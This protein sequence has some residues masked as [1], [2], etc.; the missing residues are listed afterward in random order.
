MV[1][2]TPMCCPF[3][4]PIW[5]AF[6][7]PGRRPAALSGMARIHR[8]AAATW[9]VVLESGHDPK[10]GKRLWQTFAVRG[11]KR[12]AEREAADRMA[13]VARGTYVDRS[14]ETVGEFLHRWLRPYV[15]PSLS[16]RSRLRYRDIVQGVLVPPLGGVPI[17]QLKPAHILAME[18]E[19]RTTGNRKTGSAL[20]PASVRKVHNVLHRAL[21]HAVAWQVIPVNPADAVDRPSVPA[22]T[23][24][25]LGPDQARALLA[26]LGGR[27]FEAQGLPVGGL[28]R[29]HL[30]SPVHR[31]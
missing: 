4:C 18:Q 9:E 28:R 25:T 24:R 7:G 23:P 13:A 29:H 21:R 12:D 19:V 1:D 11:T 10:T 27:R 14:K 15:E 6:G 31:G 5:G 22:V 3:V 2:A 16:L 17:Q 30:T 20:A 26:A 8:R